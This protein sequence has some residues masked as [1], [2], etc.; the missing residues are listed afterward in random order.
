MAPRAL[1]STFDAIAI[2]F[3]AAQKTIN[4]DHQLGKIIININVINID[5]GLMVPYTFL[6]YL[7][8]GPW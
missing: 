4:H 7:N 5:V 3:L 2:S 1:N 8:H 6:I